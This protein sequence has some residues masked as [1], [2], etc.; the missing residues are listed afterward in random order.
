MIKAVIFDMGGVLIDLYFERSRNCF[1]EKLEYTR[2]KEELDPC[3]QKGLFMQLEGGAITE[4]EFK[5]AVLS[6]SKPGCTGED[7]EKC[8]HAMLGGIAEDKVE[9]LKE[10]SG[11]HGIYMLSNNNPVAWKRCHEIF[12]EHGI[13]PEKTFNKL[14]L[15]YQMKLLKPGLEIYRQALRE[16]IADYA[17]RR[18]GEVLNP[19]EVLF[20]DD[21][22]ANVDAA[23]AA[24]MQAVHYIPGTDLRAT[25]GL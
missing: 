3:H 20:V 10:L 8:F 2:I 24:G 7:V 18:N 25:L 15:S 14:F 1:L 21:S 6:H 17:D 5:T 16:A 23:K 22:Q 19:S 13:V 11:S 12:L 4:E 9:L